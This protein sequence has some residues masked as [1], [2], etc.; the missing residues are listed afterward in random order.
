MTHQ[1]VEASQHNRALI[2][3]ESESLDILGDELKD[4]LSWLD[5]IYLKQ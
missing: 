2:K 5:L 1:L 3:R 4:L